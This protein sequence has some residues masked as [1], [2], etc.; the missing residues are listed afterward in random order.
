MKV[1]SLLATLGCM[2]GLVAS[3]AASDHT[4][5]QTNQL[6]S[7]GGLSQ[8]ERDLF[9]EVNQARA[10][11]GVYASYLERLKPLFNGKEYKPSGQE[12][13]MTREGWSAVE[14]A[15]K[16]L[17]SAKPQGPLNISQ[18]LRLAALAHVKDQSAT[19]A[20]GHKGAD[21]TFIEERVKPF[22]AWQGGI[23]ENLAYGK[24]SAR[25]QVLTWLI[26][27]GFPSR[28]HRNRLMS[29]NYR[30][31]GVSCGPHPGFGAMCVLT[32]AGGFVELEPVKPVTSTQTN[33]NTNANSNKSKKPINRK[34][35]RS[36]SH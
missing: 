26:D 21:S 28:G 16:F 5:S 4:L 12:A 22:G 17:R 33:A 2:V 31:A 35:T 11:P 13:F 24:Q 30:V 15:I 19:G 8:T 10:H 18:G 20:T 25:E 6:A 27:D 14:E 1:R 3:F 32:L 29:G 7:D 36:R 34:P 23:G 9:S